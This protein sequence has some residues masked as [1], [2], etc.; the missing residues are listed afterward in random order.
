MPPSALQMLLTIHGVMTVWTDE[1]YFMH[2]MSIISCIIC[3]EEVPSPPFLSLL[4]SLFPCSS[5][6]Y[7][8]LSS[9]LFLSCLSA[10]LHTFTLWKMY[11]CRN[12]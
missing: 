7:F 11:L 4:P 8:S 2:L 12:I 10:I 1:H 3:L 5:F 9:L 6:Q